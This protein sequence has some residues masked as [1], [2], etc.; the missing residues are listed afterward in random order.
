DDRTGAPTGIEH[1]VAMT[2]HDSSHHAEGT[3]RRDIGDATLEQLRADVTRLA[4]EWISGQPLP[5]FQEMRRIRDRIYAALDRRLWHHD[6]TELYFLLG[7]L[8]DLMGIT[9]R[10]LGYPHAGEE[11]LRAGWAYAT[12]IDHRPLMA[13]LRLELAYHAY[14]NNQPGH[15]R[16]LAQSGLDY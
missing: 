10:C 8:H 15:S 5:L 7:V 12:V 11:L 13:R 14:G 9:A 1:E 16:D 3:E 2:A 6:Q 4:R